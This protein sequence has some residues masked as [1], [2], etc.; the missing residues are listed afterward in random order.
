MPTIS[1]FFGIYITM[2]Y[3]DHSP[4]HFH[5][6]YAEYSAIYSITTLEVTRGSLPSRAHAMVVE[7]A[8]LHRDELM[9][10][11]GNARKGQ[12]LNPI[13]PLK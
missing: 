5:A 9:E 11:W 12:E 10:N 13:D 7:W 8:S 3:N 1:E 6:E 2:Y 4:P